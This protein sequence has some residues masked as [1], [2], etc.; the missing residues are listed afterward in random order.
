MEAMESATQENGL[1]KPKTRPQPKKG[2]APRQVRFITEY[3][4]NGGNRLV[5]AKSAGY[6]RRV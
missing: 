4:K 6:K 5:A 2:L 1:E 3:L